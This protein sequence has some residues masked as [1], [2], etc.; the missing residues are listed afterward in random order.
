MTEH[1]MPSFLSSYHHIRA[2]WASADLA[3]FIKTRLNIL[4]LWCSI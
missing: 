4:N 1:S 2:H 3:L